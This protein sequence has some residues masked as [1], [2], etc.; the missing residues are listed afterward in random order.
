MASF[1]PLSSFF[2]MTLS[3]ASAAYSVKKCHL[4]LSFPFIMVFLPLLSSLLCNVTA[5]A[6]RYF[7]IRSLA[8]V[9]S[10][11]T[12]DSLSKIFPVSICLSVVLCA[13]W[14]LFRGAFTVA[15]TWY[16]SHIFLSSFFFF[17]YSKGSS[18]R[19]TRRRMVQR[20]ILGHSLPI[21]LFAT[22][23]YLHCV[24]G[25][26]INLYYIRII[27]IRLVH[28]TLCGSNFEDGFDGETSIQELDDAVWKRG[29]GEYAQVYPR[30]NL[31]VFVTIFNFALRW[32]LLVPSFLRLPL[33]AATVHS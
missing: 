22:H 18:L 25:T 24:R 21:S 3:I 7:R 6:P 11:Q 30:K 23:L 29:N 26:H 14:N 28:Y 33:F 13:P 12:L 17:T 4:F 27:S 31:C 1:F 2:A 15:V 16:T 19:Y 8:S 32:R 10:L 20:E 5:Q 9:V